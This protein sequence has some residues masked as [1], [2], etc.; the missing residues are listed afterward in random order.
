MGRGRRRPALA[1]T[2]SE[3]AQTLPWFVEASFARMLGPVAGMRVARL[4]QRLL[5]FPDYATRRFAESA[6]SYARDEAPL[7]VNAT[8]CRSLAAE[9]EALAQRAD[10]LA[11]RVDRLPGG[12]KRES[13]VGRSE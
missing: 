7:G 5:S 9:N 4:G 11:E 8:E 1:A 3:L 6:V 10:A 2:L 13:T 12:G